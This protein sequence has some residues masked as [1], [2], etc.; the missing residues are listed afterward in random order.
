MAT[1]EDAGLV[2]EKPGRLRV[3]QVGMGHTDDVMCAEQTVWP[4]RS[5]V[6]AQR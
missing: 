5:V 6:G 3:E 4:Q 1:P 2:A